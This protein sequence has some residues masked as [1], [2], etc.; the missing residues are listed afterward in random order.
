[1]ELIIFAYIVTGLFVLYREYRRVRIERFISFG[2]L[3]FAF[4][5]ILCL[6]IPGLTIWKGDVSRCKDNSIFY[7]FL[8]YIISLISLMFSYLGYNKG[9]KIHPNVQAVH[10]SSY[11]KL[12][13]NSKNL[14]LTSMVLMIISFVSLY[15]WSSGYGGIFNVMLVGGQIRASFLHSTNSLMF[16]KHL[17]PVSIIS[18]LLMYT[19]L[20]IN[21]NRSKRFFRLLVL[22]LSVAISFIYIMANDGRMLA[23][24][25]LLYFILIS[26]KDHY[27]VKHTSMRK[28]ILS[29]LVIIV[30][31]FFVIIQSESWF[32]DIRKTEAETSEGSAIDIVLREFN[33]IYIGL[34][35]ALYSVIEN[36]SHYT[37]IN[38]VVN[39]LFAWLPTSLKPLMLDD[40]WDYNTILINDGG[41]GQS[42][43]NLPTQAFYDLGLFGVVFISFGYMYLVGAI[44]KKF[45]GQISTVAIVFYVVFGFY[46]ARGV[47]YFSMYNIMINF[48]FIVISWIL[49]KYCFSKI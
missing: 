20:F 25:Y 47:A 36:V 1:M 49:Y 35:T 4:F 41:Y 16:L 12:K 31:V 44:E 10:N 42:P 26:L 3:C 15:Y 29:T 48:F 14:L 27:E 8:S 43:T 2:N 7:V 5:A 39:G 46:F 30:L 22:V 37:I 6:I 23:G 45:R 17:I 11:Q 40:V 13:D 34:N 32:A 19:D 9:R 18:S 33:F 28:I 38:D 24:T 21:K